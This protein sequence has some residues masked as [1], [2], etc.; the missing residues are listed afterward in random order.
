MQFLW[1]SCLS[2]TRRA[3]H[4]LDNNHAHQLGATLNYSLSKRSMVYAEGV[5]QKA[6][7]GSHAAINGIMGPNGSSSTASQAIARVGLRT[8]F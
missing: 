3:E 4:E 5:Y 8:A 2:D 7:A 1:D 6:S